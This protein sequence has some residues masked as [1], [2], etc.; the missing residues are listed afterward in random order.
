MCIKHLHQYQWYLI[1]H[2]QFFPLIL[3]RKTFLNQSIIATFCFLNGDLNEYFSKNID[4]QYDIRE[5]R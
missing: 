4:C 2:K 1:Q 3:K 5:Q